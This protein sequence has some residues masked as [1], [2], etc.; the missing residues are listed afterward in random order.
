MIPEYN[1]KILGNLLKKRILELKTS[2]FNQESAAK[3]INLESRYFRRIL[4]GDTGISFGT[5]LELCRI[6]ELNPVDILEKI[7]GGD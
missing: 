4:K 3:Q 7:Q 2:R 5:F 1:R 6:L